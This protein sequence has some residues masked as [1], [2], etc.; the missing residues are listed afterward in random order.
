MQCSDLG[1]GSTR[2]MR[3]IAE[4][5]VENP[6]SGHFWYEWGAEFTLIPVVLIYCKYRKLKLITLSCPL[7]SHGPFYCS[8]VICGFYVGTWRDKFD[9][10]ITLV[11]CTQES[12]NRY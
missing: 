10:F 7:V 5:M 3:A 9:L 6:H 1:A 8:G 11:A 12:A 2:N 4:D